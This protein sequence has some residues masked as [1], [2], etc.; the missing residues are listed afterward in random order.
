MEAVPAT[1]AISLTLTDAVAELDIQVECQ[2]AEIIHHIV[3]LIQEIHIQQ[4]IIIVSQEGTT[5]LTTGQIHIQPEIMI[6]GIRVLVMQ[7]TIQQETATILLPEI[8]ITLLLQQTG[9][10]I[11]PQAE[12]LI[13]QQD[14][15][16]LVL[17]E[18]V[19]AATAVVAVEAVAEEEEEVNL[20]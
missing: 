6:Q 7:I 20:L 17:A 1:Q 19:Q 12:V 3:T 10:T 4:E 8:T 14:H 2:A 11:I 15:T 13:H 5:I 18:A 16:R 9:I